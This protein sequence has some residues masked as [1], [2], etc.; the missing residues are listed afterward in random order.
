MRRAVAALAEHKAKERAEL[1][2]ALADRGVPMMTGHVVTAC[3]ELL[4]DDAVVVVAGGNTA[5]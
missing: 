5:V 1:D 2:G 3:R 4:D